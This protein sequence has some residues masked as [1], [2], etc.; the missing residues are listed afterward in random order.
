MGV[1]A[2]RLVLSLPVAGGWS[3]TGAATCVRATCDRADRKSGLTRRNLRVKKHGKLDAKRI[4]APITQP[5]Q[6]I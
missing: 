1:K 3:G 5:P 4:F 2:G 6:N